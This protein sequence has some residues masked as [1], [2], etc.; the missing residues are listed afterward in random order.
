M[1]KATVASPPSPF[2]I[3]DW[4]F[5]KDDGFV[6][7]TRPC[8]CVKY[9]LKVSNVLRLQGM[10]ELQIAPEHRKEQDRHPPATFGRLHARELH[11]LAGQARVQSFE[12][13]ALSVAFIASCPNRGGHSGPLAQHRETVSWFSRKE[14]KTKGT[15]KGVCTVESCSKY[16]V[17]SIG[18]S[19]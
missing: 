17:C 2:Q 3:L 9:P 16:M 15:S 19:T 8:Y 18:H 12:L 14:G 1:Q 7:H 11:G 5:A 13:D 4:R 10:P 6:P